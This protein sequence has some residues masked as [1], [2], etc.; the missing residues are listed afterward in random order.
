MHAA[1]ELE[2]DRQGDRQGGVAQ[3]LQ[4]FEAMNDHAQPIRRTDFQIGRREET[5]EQENRLTD[6]G[7][8][9]DDR[10]I[11]VEQGETVG[12]LAERCRRTQQAMP[13]GIGLDH[14]P[15]PGRTGVPFRHQVVVTQRRQIDAGFNRARHQADSSRSLFLA[16]S[17]KVRTTLERKR[18]FG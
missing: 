12:N 5:F 2:V 17:T 11:E 7:L 16:K 6:T 13:V 1:V 9:Q 8:A 4:L 18:S 10:F 3:H 14:R 15:G